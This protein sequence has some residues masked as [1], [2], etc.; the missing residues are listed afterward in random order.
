MNE[1]TGTGRP[2]RR[3]QITGTWH[4]TSQ[5]FDEY[6]SNNPNV[7]AWMRIG[8][9]C[10]AHMRVGGVCETSPDELARRIGVSKTNLSREVRKAILNGF[11]AEG[12]TSHRLIAPANSI[13]MTGSLGRK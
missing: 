11:L 4:K 10:Y 9:F 1:T 5:K 12:S 6:Q 7:P 8:F 3:S 13:E 2:Q